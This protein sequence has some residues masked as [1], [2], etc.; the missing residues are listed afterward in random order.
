MKDQHT[1]KHTHVLPIF[2]DIYIYKLYIYIYRDIYYAYKYREYTD[3]YMCVCVCV[4]LLFY[5]NLRLAEFWF[6]HREI[7]KLRGFAE[8][9]GGSGVKKLP[10]SAGDVG[11]IPGS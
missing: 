1:Y 11:S 5:H 6:L 4:S 7:Q 9:P 10:A 8:F 3:I 2:M